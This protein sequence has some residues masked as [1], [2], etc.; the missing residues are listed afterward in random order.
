MNNMFDNLI[1]IVE[2]SLS[3]S[4]CSNVIKYYENNSTNHKKGMIGN[5]KSDL[6]VINTKIKNSID[7]S[8]DVNDMCSGMENYNITEELISELK[9]HCEKYIDGIKKININI[10]KNILFKDFNI[11]KYEMGK[12]KF[13]YHNDFY[14]DKQYMKYRFLNFIFYLNTVECGGETQILN[15]HIIKPSTGKL[16]LFPSDWMFTHRG[17]IPL[18]NDKYIITGWVLF[19]I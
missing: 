9:I 13:I 5:I 11:Q 17:N 10:N 8:F 16:A 18:S 14:I 12:G 1:Y 4:F 6:P 3:E 19:E 15:D 7:M 2:N